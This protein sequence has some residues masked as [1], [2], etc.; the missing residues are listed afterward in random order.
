GRSPFQ[1]TD[2]TALHIVGR[3]RLSIWG[4]WPEQL[5]LVSTPF[6]SV[7]RFSRERPE[8]PGGNREASDG[9]PGGSP[10]AGKTGRDRCSSGRN[11]ARVLENG[12]PARRSGDDHANHSIRLP[13]GTSGR[14]CLRIPSGGS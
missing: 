7:S 14:G 13:G 12:G 1:P 2:P 11:S 3:P 8:F 5:L 6:G 9:I 4:C 10:K